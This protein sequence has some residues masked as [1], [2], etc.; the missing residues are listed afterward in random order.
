MT[1]LLH[2]YGQIAWHDEVTIIGD[3]T[4][5]TKLRNAIEE[6][7]NKDSSMTDGVVNDGEGFNILIINDNNIDKLPL[8]YSDEV[9]SEKNQDIWKVLIDLIAKHFSQERLNEYFSKK[10]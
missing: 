1:N 6:A 7:I 8:P 5:L 10:I 9:A 3:K 4:S 2:I